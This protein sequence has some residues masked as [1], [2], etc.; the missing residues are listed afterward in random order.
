[1][2]DY[3]IK[4]KGECDVTFFGTDDNTIVV[5][6]TVKFDTDCKKADIEISDTNPVKIGIPSR[7]EKVE[8]EIKE[9]RL[10]MSNLTA[11]QFEIDG[12]GTIVVDIENIT[13]SIEIN[14]IGGSAVKFRH[15]RIH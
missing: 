9:S 11:E 15:K 10:K 7:A 3:D 8:I 6:A 14:M 4:I 2:N 5:P 1:M 13:G 12:K